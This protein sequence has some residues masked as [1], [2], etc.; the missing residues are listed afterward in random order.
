MDSSRS[1]TIITDRKIL[2]RKYRTLTRETSLLTL[3]NEQQQMV[4]LIVYN[5]LILSVR[6]SALLLI[7]FQSS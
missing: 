3:K 5:R 6:Q 2:Q 1:N 4:L 7:I